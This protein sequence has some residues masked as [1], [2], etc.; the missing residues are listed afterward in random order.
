MPAQ[1]WWFWRKI[2]DTCEC[3]WDLKQQRNHHTFFLKFLTPCPLFP[4]LYKLIISS[5]KKKVIRWKRCAQMLYCRRSHRNV[6][7]AWQRVD[8]EVE[9]SILRFLWTD[10][11]VTFLFP[12]SSSSKAIKDH[13]NQTFHQHFMKA[14]N[15]C[16]YKISSDS[17]KIHRKPITYAIILVFTGTQMSISFLFVVRKNFGWKWGWKRARV[18]A[19]R[20]KHIS[21]RGLILFSIGDAL[22]GESENIPMKI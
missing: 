7:R 20:V 18:D 8:S 2:W 9:M 4:D 13:S 17:I 5:L 14:G 12:L 1:N 3:V 6:S 15:I 22:Y 10:W 16:N 19:K 11:K 21:E